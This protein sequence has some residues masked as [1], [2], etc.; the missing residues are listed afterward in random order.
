MFGQECFQAFQRIKPRVHWLILWTE[1]LSTELRA[2]L[3]M[4]RE[5][6]EG[7]NLHLTTMHIAASW[8]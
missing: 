1:L 4:A 3:Q 5:G 6:W 7:F 2:A 8:P